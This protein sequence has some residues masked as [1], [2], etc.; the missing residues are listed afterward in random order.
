MNFRISIQPT[1]SLSYETLYTITLDGGSGGIT[2]ENGNALA[3]DFTSSFTTAPFVDNVA[4]EVVSVTPVANATGVPVAANATVV[5]SEDMNINSL[6]ELN[7]EIRT[8]GGLLVPITLTYNPATRTATMIPEAPLAYATNFTGIVKSGAEGVKDIAGNAL[9]SDYTWSFSSETDQVAPLVVQIDPA[10]NATAVP[11]TTPVNIRFSEAMLAGS[12]TTFNIEVRDGSNNLVAGTLSYYPISFVAIFTPTEPLRYGM[13]YTVRVKSG[14]TGVKDINGN[15]LAADFVW[16]FTTEPDLIAPTITAVTPANNATGVQPTIVVTAVFSEELDVA[17]INA[18]TVELRNSANTLIPSTISYNNTTRT[19][20]I[21]PNSSLTGSMVFN[22]LIKAGASGVKDLSGNALATNYTWSFATASTSI[23]IFGPGT[24]TTNVEN[25]GAAV[26]I[27]M[28]F[29]STEAGFINGVRFYKTPGMSGVHTG[30]LWSSTGTKLAEVIFTNETASGWQQALFP[31]PVAIQPNTT[32][33]VSYHSPTGD[34]PNTNPYFTNAVT[35]GPLRALANGEDGG[36]GVYRY[37]ATPIF[38][39]ENWG[40]TNY[41]VD[42]VFSVQAGPDLVPPVINSL[43]PVR[44]A[45]SV[46]I[47][48]PIVATFNE[49]VSPASFTTGV[50]ELRNASNSVVP[51][52]LVVSQG[53]ATLTPSAP[54]SYLST[55]TV[56]IRGGVNGVKDLEGNAL[57]RDT[58]WTFTTVEPPPPA[59]TD[60]GPGGPILVL[61]S[62]SNPFSRY[63]IEILRAEGLNYFLAKNIA[64]LTATDLDNYD[65][66]VLGEVAVNNNQVAW[67]TNFVNNGGTL[68]GLRPAPAL[69]DLFGITRQTGTLSDRYLLVNTTSGPGQGIVNQT[70]QFH[71]AADLYTLSGA[72]S[73]ATLYSSATTAT[74]NPAVTLRQVGTNGGKA[75]AFTYDLAKSIVYTRQGNPAW[76]GQKRDGTFGPIRSD[77]MFFG[78]TSTD[79]ID[80]NKVA[81]PQADEQQR[82]LVNILLQGNMHRKPLPRFWFLPRGLKAAI[83][84]TGDDH[85]N[86]GTTGRFN[87]YLTLGPNTPQDVADWKAVRASSYL[88]NGTPVSNADA[89]AFNN[90][91]F[92]I[93]LHLYTGCNNFTGATELGAAFDSQIEMFQEQFPSLPALISHRTHCMV[94]SDWAT[95]AKV[96]AQRGIRMD[97]NYYYWP[98]SW[99]QD[100]SGMFTGSG[101]PMR[102]ADLDGSLIDC[103]QAPTQMTDESEITLPKFANDLLNRALGTEGYYGVFVANMHTDSANHIGSTHIINSALSRNVPVISSKQ[104]VTWL[105]G[106]NSS[107]FGEMTWNNNQLSFPVTALPGARNLKGMVPVTAHSGT[108]QYILRDGNAVS[109]TTE[110]IKGV[111]YAFF[112][113]PVGTSEFIADYGSVANR[114]RIDTIPATV[115]VVIPQEQ[116]ALQLKAEAYPNPSASQFQLRISGGDNQPVVVRFVDAFGKVI[117]RHERMMPGSI[118]QVGATWKNGVYFAE[119]V[120]GNNKTVLKLVKTGN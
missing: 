57:V 119:V 109:Y 42:V 83:V 8:A 101:M 105:D 39:N 78:G 15:L 23:S 21:T 102:F 14:A 75:V 16:N 53:T 96:Q 11:V 30:N 106:R 5:F 79:W 63:T 93:G 18:S 37:N 113:I 2:D 22:V 9:A 4:P 104:L 86:D 3:A 58:T 107:Y 20:S 76:A 120:Q 25:D 74:T 59:V 28:K 64:E 72:T 17:T 41:Y 81:I 31:S 100:R 92:E 47:A 29:R 114:G 24:S 73:L 60:N 45:T 85:Y 66:V 65:M 43:S 27:G 34:Y 94:W 6:S 71:G 97:V 90:M 98:G 111:N 103:Y 54:L 108:L 10:S 110:T 55:Y 38:P 46:S 88:Y 112:D 70:I 67:L 62:P 91:G 117:E 13:V 32:Y 89:I 40:S 115:A 84:M 61:Y 99:I 87:H 95:V 48:A 12:I 82:L 69:A 52:N 80:L 56:R 33:V 7:F 36:N 35:N 19:L 68:V 1:T 44:N 50:F 26:T 116:I 51:S 118:F 77:D 49:S